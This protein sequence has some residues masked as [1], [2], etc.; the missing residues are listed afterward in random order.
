MSKWAQR[1]ALLE[2][3]PH[4]QATDKTDTT[5]VS[6]VLSVAAERVPPN[7][8]PELVAA[9]GPLCAIAHELSEDARRL[10]DCLL[11][12]YPDAGAVY[13]RALAEAAR[14]PISMVLADLDVLHTAGLVRRSRGYWA[15]TAALQRELATVNVGGGMPTC[16]LISE[17]F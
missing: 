4:Q 8:R 3:G 17:N 13:A 15:P 10:L 11:W 14:L 9:S 6:S 5:P 2:A 7:S 1:L 12:I 16:Q